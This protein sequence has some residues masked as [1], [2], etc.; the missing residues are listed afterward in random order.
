MRRSA[1]RFSSMC[2]ASAAIIIM[3]IKRSMPR[4]CWT[5]TLSLSLTDER[6]TV[7]RLRAGA[8]S[9]PRLA[10]SV[11]P[12]K[13]PFVVVDPRAGHGPGIGGMKQDSEIGV[14]LAAGHP[15]YFIGFLPEPLPDQ[16][17]E[18]VWNAEAL[19]I[20]EV[21]RRH[22]EASG[23]PVVI[24]NCQAGWQ[25]MIMAATHPDVAGPLLIAGAPLSYWAG[26]RGKNPMRY[27]GGLLGGS[28]MTAMAGDLGAGKFDGAEPGR[29]LRI[30]GSGQHLLEQ[31]L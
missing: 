6:L 27:L 11:D 1:P 7:R 25:T 12:A 24:A 29:E 4:T 21:A 8:A 19:F 18:D 14:A 17:I 28:W 26:V 16:T 9:F 3:S 15:C 31:A 22:P 2:F 5:S 13:R 10:R 20:E 30:D 23:K